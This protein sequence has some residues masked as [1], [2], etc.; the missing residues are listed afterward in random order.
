[1]EQ[2]LP[3]QSKAGGRKG[4]QLAPLKQVVLLGEHA[5]TRVHHHLATAISLGLVGALA[6]LG[7]AKGQGGKGK[8]DALIATMKFVKV[9]KGT[10][11][12]GW[13]SDTKTSKQVEIK[14]DFEL[15]AYT[16]TQEQ[17]EAV[18]GVGSNPSYFSRQGEGKDQV[19]D[20]SDADLKQFPVERVSWRDV[21]VFV[22]KLN[23]R[24]KGKGW[25]YQLPKEAEWEYACRGGATSKEEC[26]Y[27]FYFAKGTNDL[28]SKE[29]NFYG[30]HPA[31]N[32]AKGPSLCRATKVGSYASNKLGLYDMHGNVFEWCEDLYDNKASDRVARGGGWILDAGSCRAANRSRNTP[33]ARMNDLGF[34]LARV[35]SGK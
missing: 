16:V 22:K 31:G 7:N 29:A 34:R 4:T 5:M 17:W 18:M 33:G 3:R 26:S 28:S 9:P 24:E 32:G 20:V 25:T 11:W 21:Q 23:E 13:D 27:D 10:F 14:Q 8:E 1:M 15:A 6:L 19:K 12:M 2:N 30:S 35:P